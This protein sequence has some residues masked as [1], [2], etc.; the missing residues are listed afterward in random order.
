MPLKSESVPAR[1]DM[2]SQ[3]PLFDGGKFYDSK[4]VVHDLGDYERLRYAAMLSTLGFTPPFMVPEDPKEARLTVEA[5]F[6][7]R[8]KVRSAAEKRAAAYVSGAA[9]IEFVIE[10]VEKQ[11]FRRCRREGM[12]HDE[13]VRERT[14][15]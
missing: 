12:T 14:E 3:E 13:T 2:P 8:Q 4:G 15:G 10:A 7:E 9:T 11:W 5:F 1:V 6:V